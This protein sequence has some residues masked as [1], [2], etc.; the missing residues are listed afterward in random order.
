M[1]PSCDLTTLTLNETGRT[2]YSNSSILSHGTGDLLSSF[3]LTVIIISNNKPHL[4]VCATCSKSTADPPVTK[5][6]RSSSWVLLQ[7]HTYDHTVE[8]VGYYR[9]L[10]PVSHCGSRQFHQDPWKEEDRDPSSPQ[11]KRGKIPTHAF[12]QYALSAHTRPYCARLTSDERSI[13]PLHSL[14]DS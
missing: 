3:C 1:S 14:A 8:V 4:P 9:A 12:K 2:G 6:A 10:G 11:A 13:S 5:G 7:K